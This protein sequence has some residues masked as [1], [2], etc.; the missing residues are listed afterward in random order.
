[1]IACDGSLLEDIGA[2]FHLKEFVAGTDI[3]HRGDLK[4]LL[5]DLEDFVQ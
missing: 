3:P 4:S 2:T 5:P 1:M